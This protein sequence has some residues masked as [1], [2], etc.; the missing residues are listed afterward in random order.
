MTT[1]RQRTVFLARAAAGLAVAALLGAGLRAAVRADAQ[2][3]QVPARADYAAV[4]AALDR[5]VAHEI[6]DKKIPALS[7]ALVDDQ[8]VVYARGYG[9]ADPEKKVPATAATVHRVGSVSKLFTDVGMMR[10]AEQG[11]IDIDAPITRY[12]PEFQPKNP[13]GK[14]VTLRMLTSHRAGLIR[15]PPVGNYFETTEPSLA[16]TIRSLNQTALVYEPGTKAKYSNAGIATVGYVLERTQG[17]PFAPWLKKT[18]LTPMGMSRSSFLPEPDL[19]AGMAKA[20]MWTYDGRFFE[21]PHFQ[22]GMAPCGSM[23]STVLDLARFLSVLFARG[24]VA[25]AAPIL[26]PETLDVMWTPQF[27]PA[28]AKQGFGIGFAVAEQDGRRIVGHDG[29]IYGFATTLAGMPDDKLGVV[30]VATKDCANPVVDRIAEAAL[31]MMRAAKAGQPLPEPVITAAIPRPAARALAGRYVSGDKAV[32]LE[33]RRGE[34]YLTRT[35]NDQRLRLRAL[36]DGLVTDDTNGYGLAVA[37]TPERVVIGSET[38]ARAATPAPSALPEPRPEWKG[39]IGEYG[40]DHDTLYVFE[41]D[42]QLN[43][44]IEW[45]TAYPLTETGKDTYRFPDWGL[46]AGEPVVFERD[47]Q[48]RATGVNAANVVFKRRAD[49]PEGN[50]T[51]RITPVRPVPELRKEALASAPPAESGDLRKADL[52]DLTKLD[53]TIKLDIR[54][55][56]TNNF[57]STPVYTEA[58]AFLQRPAAEGLVRA[59]RKL[60]EKGY[61][62]LIHDGYRP[63]YVTKVFWEATPP[64]GKI[65]V[66]NPADGSRHNRGCAVDLT[67]YDRASGRPVEMPSVYD[68]QSS[69]AFPAYPGGTSRQRALR[70]TLR[71]AMED[72]GFEV[73]DY[74]W[75]HFDYKDWKSYPILNLTF[76]RIAG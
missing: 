70:E 51:F 32:E 1:T 21:A 42:G 47:G 17:E 34:L 44:L 10:L 11:K 14:P 41:K 49:G 13:Y 23:Y 75:W 56:S 48:G 22:L 27:A 19:V 67:L 39:L 65:F 46:Y 18:V 8:T 68:E 30:A 59:H 38:F 71:R 50:A 58:R 63:W 24:R 25:G 57:L 66:A 40:W 52:V 4:A 7:L 20:Y 76:D 28:G 73:Y 33:E 31:G 62:L 74:E 6:E 72:E 15:E 9:Y 53:P 26:K 43:A 60:Q 12:L 64:E 16:D 69:R 55:A 37:A 45:F 36:G 35:G 29:A 3:E 61:G 5:F 2:P 54:Y